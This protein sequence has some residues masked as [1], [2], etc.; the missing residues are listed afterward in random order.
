MVRILHLFP[1]LMNLYGEYANLEVLKK[2]LQDQDLEVVIDKK[3]LQDNI[4]FKNYDM[5]YMGSGTEE[6]QMIALKELKKYEDDF[7][8]YIDNDG[9]VLFT[10]N[11]MELLGNSINSEKALGL[12]DFNTEVDDKR[13]TGD[14][15]VSLTDVGKI[16]GFIN[17]SSRIIGNYN[18]KLFSYVYKDNNLIDNDFEGYHFKNVYGTHI[19]GPILSKNPK[20]IE[21]FVK[22][23]LP[24]EQIFEK[25]DYPFEESSFNITLKELTKR[26]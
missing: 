1:N 26:G 13:Y 16:V 25:R 7:V 15:V 17:K 4:F 21:I 14:V 12:V 5:V 23:L 18:C 2:H 20:F 19:I 3:D 11:A 24:K 10:G 8:S 22:K 9:L 6:N